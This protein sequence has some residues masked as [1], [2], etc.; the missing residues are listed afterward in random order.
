VL[1][2]ERFVGL[3]KEIRLQDGG[4]SGLKFTWLVWSQ[5]FLLCT[6]AS[7]PSGRCRLETA[8]SVDEF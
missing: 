5:E 6:F 7:S 1:Q 2:E 3:Y 4:G 8:G